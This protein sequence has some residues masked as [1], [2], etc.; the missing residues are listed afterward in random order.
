MFAKMST[1]ANIWLCILFQHF[2]GYPSHYQLLCKFVIAH[3][4]VYCCSYCKI[5]I[6]QYCVNDLRPA[7]Y[8][9]RDKKVKAITK[10]E[11]EE[12]E[13][14]S[15]GAREEGK[16]FLQVIES[17]NIIDLSKPIEQEKTSAW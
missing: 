12:D 2:V 14:Y 4:F 17:M 5:E 10:E 1:K 6:A 3:I 8:A 16:E 15:Q 11:E 9:H 13:G 7:Y